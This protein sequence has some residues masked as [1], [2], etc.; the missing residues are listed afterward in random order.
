M[1]F[2]D[3][4][5]RVFGIINVIDL[6]VVLFVVAVVTAGFAL[7]LQ[8]GDSDSESRPEVGTRFVTLDLGTQPGYVVER[9]SEGDATIG[10]GG[11]QNLT[12]TDVYFGPSNGHSSTVTV[13]ARIVGFPGGRAF[14][15]VGDPLILG[16]K[17]T[18]R[19]DEYRASGVVT[20]VDTD[21]ATLNV[22][23]TDI[24]L[25]TTMPSEAVAQLSIGDQ[26][27]VNGRTLATVESVTVYPTEDPTARRVHLGLS[28]QTMLRQERARF[29]GG[30][31]EVGR[32]LSLAFGQYDVN[33]RITRIGHLTPPGNPAT[34]TAV[35]KLSNVA[36]DSADDIRVGMTETVGGTRYAEVV[37]TRTEPAEV[38]LRSQ[39]GNIFLKEHPRNLDVYL[40]VQLRTRTGADGLTFH[41]RPLQLNRQVVFDF[42]LLTVRGDV[43]E[44]RQ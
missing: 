19:T 17:L 4:Q 34:T 33:G 32:S 27:R 39:D 28:L 41:G 3:E 10:P 5:G 20:A 43:V 25:A 6:F 30:P 36:P 13:R 31:V 1:E 24:L 15:F 26:Y 22:T 7:A 8:P 40:T 29:G 23:T 12:V 21:G 44:I 16:R 38:V 11:P 35:V 9:I 42:G 14:T 37:E 18:V 2:L